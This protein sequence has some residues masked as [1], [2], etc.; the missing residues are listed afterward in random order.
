MLA[1][2]C[3]L[4]AIN[5][6]LK[7]IQFSI[8]WCRFHAFWC[9][10]WRFGHRAVEQKSRPGGRLGVAPHS[11]P[12]PPARPPSGQSACA[13]PAARSDS[14]QRRQIGG[15]ISNFS[16]F[17][18]HS[19]SIRT[20]PLP[21]DIPEIPRRFALKMSRRSRLLSGENGGFRNIRKLF[22]F[23]SE[24]PIVPTNGRDFV[25]QSCSTV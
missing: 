4:A 20:F 23:G 8:E 11:P 17:L 3:D 7:R 19:L 16:S 14:L 13:L 22:H 9:S 21:I 10:R 25:F 2:C 5:T 15:I 6:R 24:C 1:Q 18:R 12:L